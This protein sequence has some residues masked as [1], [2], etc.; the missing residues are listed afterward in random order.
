MAL[1]YYGLAW[2]A[3]SNLIGRGAEVEFKGNAMMNIKFVARRPGSQFLAESAD[4]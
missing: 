2:S 1:G 4:Q 3:Y